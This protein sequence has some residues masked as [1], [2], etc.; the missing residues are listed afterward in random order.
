MLSS[1]VKDRDRIEDL[2]QEVFLR[3]IRAWP[4]FRGDAEVSTY[5]YRITLNVVRDEWA[6]QRGPAANWVPLDDEGV[7]QPLT[8]PSIEH[9]ISRGQL[10][11][12]VRAALDEISHIE[13]SAFLLFHQEERTYEEIARILDLPVNTVRTHLHRGRQKLRAILRGST[14]HG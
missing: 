7:S 1:L 8:A 11:G 10:L 14:L 3:L 9:E 6:R 4:H 2:A 13:R 5:V 12:L